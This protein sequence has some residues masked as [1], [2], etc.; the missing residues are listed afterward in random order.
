[1]TTTWDH[2]DHDPTSHVSVLA[3]RPTISMR[4]M[5]I[6]SGGFA[7]RATDRKFHDLGRANL[8]LIELALASDHAVGGVSVEPDPLSLVAGALHVVIHWGLVTERYHL[9]TISYALP[10]EL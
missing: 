3:E 8:A 10:G 1:M 6:S 9:D 2:H 4:H 5:I 7:D